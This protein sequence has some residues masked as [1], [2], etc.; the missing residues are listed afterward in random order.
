MINNRLTNIFKS[1]NEPL[2]NIYFTAGFPH[3]EDTI[4][5]LNELNNA[6][7]D[8]VEIGMPYSDP[9]ADGPTIQ[10]SSMVALKNGIKLKDIFRQIKEARKTIE[11]PIV[12]MGYINQVMQYGFENFIHSCKDSGV[13]GLIIPDLP[14]DVYEKEYKTLFEENNIAISF[15]ITPQTDDERIKY[16]ANLSNGFL[17]V[18]SSF[19]VTGS[20]ISV[21]E[22]QFLYLEKIKN[23]NL[24][25][26][27]MVGFGISDKETFDTFSKFTNGCIIGSAFINMLKKDGIKGINNFIKDF[28]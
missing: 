8:I 22:E 12:L 6:K 9:L 27:T 18:V 21:K 23:L 16:L 2:L 7:C 4:S 1:S 17:Y 10:N 3:K 26:N 15:L 19:S 5:I 24:T 13:D 14:A 25:A 11:I 20:S 28:K